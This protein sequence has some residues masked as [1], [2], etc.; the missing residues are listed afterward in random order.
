MSNC[1]VD[2]G[3]WHR[4]M[5]KDYLGEVEQVRPLVSDPKSADSGYHPKMGVRNPGVDNTSCFEIRRL[6]KTPNFGVVE[7]TQH[8]K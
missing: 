6:S 2:I 5:F 1:R 3:V 8:L 4:Y 7:P